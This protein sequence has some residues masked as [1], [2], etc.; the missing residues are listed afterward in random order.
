MKKRECKLFLCVNTTAKTVNSLVNISPFGEW[1]MHSVTLQ[2]LFCLVRSLQEW[3]G[4][5]FN[6]YIKMYS[7]LV[8]L[9]CNFRKPDFTVYCCGYFFSLIKWNAYH[10]R[11]KDFYSR[12]FIYFAARISQILSFHYIYLSVDGE[13]REIQFW[14]ANSKGSSYF[15]L[16]VHGQTLFR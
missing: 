9:I 16:A 5:T 15:S 4:L 11:K 12:F 7:A 2:Y 1:C 10:F 8:V 13:P 3:Y 14:I 6:I